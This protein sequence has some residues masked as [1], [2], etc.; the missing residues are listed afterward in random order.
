MEAS[1]RPVTEVLGHR[2]YLWAG[3]I[4]TRE[5]RFESVKVENRNQ[6]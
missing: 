3:N 5:F 1:R 4:K 2:L 6:P